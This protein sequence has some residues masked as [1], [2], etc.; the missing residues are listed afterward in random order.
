MVSRVSPGTV[1]RS[2]TSRVWVGVT[3]KSRDRIHITD[4]QS[5]EWCHVSPGT[6]YRSQTDRVW[7]GVMGKSRD[8]I[9]ITD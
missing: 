9:Q 8:R 3:G 7:G 6:V 5:V 1:Y 2:Q 4:W